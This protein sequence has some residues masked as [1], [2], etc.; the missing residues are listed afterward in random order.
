ML[1]IAG[2]VE[3]LPELPI[4]GEPVHSEGEI[5]ATGTDEA[6]ARSLAPLLAPTTDKSGASESIPVHAASVESDSKKR[7]NPRLSLGNRGFSGVST[8]WAIQDSNL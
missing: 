7:E 5:R 8:E 2:A 6:A 3:L 4:T 1:G